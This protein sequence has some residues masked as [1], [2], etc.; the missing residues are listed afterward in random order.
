[1]DKDLS[2]INALALKLH[3]SLAEADAFTLQS[4]AE[5]VQEVRELIE[6]KDEHWQAETA[7]IIIHGLTLLKRHGSSQSDIDALLLSRVGRFKEKI[8]DAIRKQH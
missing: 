3:G 7:D 1:M 5:H 6:K 2:D 4:L 8:A